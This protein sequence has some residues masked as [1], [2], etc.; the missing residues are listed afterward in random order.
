M[1]CQMTPANGQPTNGLPDLA[2]AG[3]P[4]NTTLLPEQRE[5]ISLDRLA[6]Y[7]RAFDVAV[8]PYRRVEP[9]YSGSSTR[10][11][12]HLAAG[13][14]VEALAVGARPRGHQ[15]DKSDRR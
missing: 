3:T 14:E 11:Y 1:P 6:A 12:E 9:T 2:R 8:L 13:P 15:A 10:F 4:L 5:V 7:A